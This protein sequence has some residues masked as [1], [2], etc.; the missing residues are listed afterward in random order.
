M[1]V[2]IDTSV[3]V[4][5]FLH[6]GGFIDRL[7]RSTYRNEYLICLSAA[8]IDECSAKLAQ[9]GIAEVEIEEN[10]RDMEKLG[11]LC[12]TTRYSRLAVAKDDHIVGCVRQCR[13][14]LVVTNDKQLI[15]KLKKLGIAAIRPSQFR[16]YFSQE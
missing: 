1:Y 13:A 5:A 8:I 3:L 9:L 12:D 4:A 14:E 16:A 7:L 6:R 15:A 11:V 2:V 10:H